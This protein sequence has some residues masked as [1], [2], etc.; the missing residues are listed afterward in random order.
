[1]PGP[2][3]V[4]ER[5][6]ELY[7]LDAPLRVK[8]ENE[9]L[10]GRDPGLAL[11]EGCEG[12]SERQ[13]RQSERVFREMILSRVEKAVNTAPEYAALRRVYLSR[14]A[15]EW[16]RERSRTASTTF[17][18]LIDSGDIGPRTSR[19][20]WKPVDVFDAYVRSYKKGEFKVTREVG[21]FRYSYFYG[22][23]DFTTV[24]Y[25]TATEADLRRRWGTLPGA[26]G[27]RSAWLTGASRSAENPAREMTPLRALTVIATWVVP[28]GLAVVVVLAYHRHRHRPR[29]PVPY[30]TPRGG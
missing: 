27:A 29:P 3:T 2:A 8:L 1:M 13:S 14:V 30:G 5:G 17:T 10:A 16:Y 21:S 19:Q 28:F 11:P 26:Q 7:I 25:G 9:Y 6:D 23:I 18:P 15:A 12:Q 20:A 22:G 24:S 4:H